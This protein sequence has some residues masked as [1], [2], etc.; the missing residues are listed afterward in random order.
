[1]H[2]ALLAAVARV[3]SRLGKAEGAIAG[4]RL[5]TVPAGQADQLRALGS[6]PA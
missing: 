2:W 4:R 3:E 6:V 1:M 5:P